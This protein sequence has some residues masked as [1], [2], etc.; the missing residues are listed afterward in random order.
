MSPDGSPVSYLYRSIDEFCTVRVVLRLSNCSEESLKQY[1]QHLE[2]RLDTFA[3]DPAE[4]VGDN[5][6][7]TRDLVFSGAV[8]GK[9]EDPIIVYNEFEGENERGSHTY[10]IW[11]VPTFISKSGSESRWGCI[12]IC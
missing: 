8:S 7:A 12:T 6:T 11:S 10:V 4:S 1:L 2:V 5:P 3:I 9:E